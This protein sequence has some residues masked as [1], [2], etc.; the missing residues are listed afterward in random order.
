MLIV[1]ILYF[2]LLALNK[3]NKCNG[4]CNNINDPYA[5]ICVPDI[6]ENLNVRVVNLM[7]GNN[8]TR[9]MKWHE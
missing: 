3:V 6:V 7:C 2:I 5:R 9:H 1:I 4:H 8:E